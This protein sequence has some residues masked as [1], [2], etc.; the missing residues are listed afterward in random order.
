MEKKSLKEVT[1]GLT[2][3]ID[4]AYDIEKSFLKCGYFTVITNVYICGELCYRV[5]AMETK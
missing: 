1:A 2:N 3:N 4:E 5:I